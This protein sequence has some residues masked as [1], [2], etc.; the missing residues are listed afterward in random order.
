MQGRGQPESTTPAGSLVSSATGSNLSEWVDRHSR[1]LFI[2]PAVFLIL[3]FSIFPL[4][5]SLLITFTR[6]RPRAGG[7]QIRWVGFKNF[8]KLFTGSEQY[9]LLGTFEGIGIFGWVV[10]VVTAVAMIYWLYRYSQ[11][12]FRLV[13]FAGRLITASA[14]FGIAV[15]FGAT[16]FSGNNFGT[17]PMTLIYVLLGCS[18]QFL[19][20]LG[21]AYLCS[22]P[23]A[24]RAFFRLASHTSGGCW[25][26]CG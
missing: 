11:Q 14:T 16:L 8:K 7:Y 12:D 17:I 23:I 15:L 10:I 19:I 13:G 6:I 5:A 9:H 22:L 26:T 2:F 20:G 1:Q 3:V 24:G 4:V 25:R 21:L 18:V